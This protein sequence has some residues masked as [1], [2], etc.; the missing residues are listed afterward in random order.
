MHRSGFRSTLVFSLFLLFTFLIPVS[1][2]LSSA[3]LVLCVV[4]VAVLE[5]RIQVI[6]DTVKRSW[7]MVLYLLILALGLTYSDDK[8][9]GLRVLET[10]LSLLAVPIVISKL[11]DFGKE[12]MKRVFLSF[13]AGLLVASMICLAHASYRYALGQH[14]EVFFFYQFTGIIDSHPTYFAYYLIAAITYGLHQLYYEKPIISPMVLVGILLFL[15]GILLLTGGI[16]AFVSMLF[17]FAFFVLKFILEERTRKHTAAFI[18]VV[19]M[20]AGMFTFNEIRHRDP[21][22]FVVDDAWDRMVLWESALKANPNT[23]LGVGTG[24]YKSELNAY[25]TSHGMSAFADS[26]MN[27]HNQFIEAYFANGLLGLVCLLLLLIRPV[28]LSV[29]N[30]NALGALIFFPFIIYGIT[31]VFL[32]RYQG[33]VFFALMQQCFVAFYQGYKPSFSLKRA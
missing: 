25:Y 11:G 18:V 13:T 21:S 27:A 8:E 6:L 19:V 20:V 4:T 28:Y 7:D 23:L 3:A 10:S 16:T 17:V 31:E 1:Q 22:G 30:G 29:R 15:F 9:T 26:N 14:T 5:E 2:Y 32:G 33:V 24:D 12:R